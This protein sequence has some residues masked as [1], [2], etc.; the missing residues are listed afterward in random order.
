[1]YARPRIDLR[2]AY[3]CAQVSTRATGRNAR[4]TFVYI[5]RYG[6]SWY[7][8]P[9]CCTQHTWESNMGVHQNVMNTMMLVDCMGD[10]HVLCSC[11]RSRV[12]RSHWYSICT[13]CTCYQ[14][15]EWPSGVDASNHSNKR[16]FRNTR[17]FKAGALAVREEDSGYEIGALD[18]ESSWQLATESSPHS[19]VTG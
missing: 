10:E 7:S 13:Y 6:L 5:P 2:R 19:S 11:R 17:L 15:Q 3:L 14:Q 1:M 9:V 8:R 4:R 18:A 16:V 12:Q